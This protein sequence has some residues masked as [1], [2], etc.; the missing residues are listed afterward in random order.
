MRFGNVDLDVGGD[1]RLLAETI[2]EDIPAGD[3]G[4]GVAVGNDIDARGADRENRDLEALG[5]RVH[6]DRRVREGRAKERE[7]VPL[8]NQGLRDLRR[9]G[10]VRRVIPGVER[11]LRAEDTAR[12]VDYL[13]G[14][15]RAFL[16]T[17]TVD[18]TGTGER[19]DGAELDSLSLVRGSGAAPGRRCTPTSGQCQRQRDRDSA[20]RASHQPLT[21]FSPSGICAQLS[22]SKPDFA[23]GPPSAPA[24]SPAAPSP[25]STTS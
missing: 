25:S 24:S 18:T 8:L 5:Q 7:Q 6:G 12:V 1:G 15:V 13:D 4:W 23:A 11:D 3:G 14:K 10:L 20:S 22:R 16:G 21:P 9:L 2:P 19:E 17:R